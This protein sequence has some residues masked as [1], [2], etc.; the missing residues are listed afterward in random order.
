MVLGRAEPRE[1]G[2]AERT[3]YGRLYSKGDERVLPEG[4]EEGSR[5]DKWQAE[6]ARGEKS[7][8]PSGKQCEMAA[9]GWRTHRVRRR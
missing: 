6:G 4:S 9:E 1:S 8:R 5:A 3:V 2:I 7:L